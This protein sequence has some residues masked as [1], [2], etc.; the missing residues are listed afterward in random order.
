MPTLYSILRG[1]ERYQNR[2]LR[3]STAGMVMNHPLYEHSVPAYLLT[4][5]IS[6]QGV[7]LST[8]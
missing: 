7:F 6:L 3:V 8:K 5:H 1:R 4:F 2:Q